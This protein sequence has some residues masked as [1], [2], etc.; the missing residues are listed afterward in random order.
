MEQTS[1]AI[2]FGNDRLIVASL[3]ADQNG[4]ED[5]AVRVRGLVDISI[6]FTQETTPY[7][8]DDNPEY[9]AVI[10]APSGDGTTTFRGMENKDYARF[11]PVISGQG[12][13]VHFGADN[14][15]KYFGITFDQKQTV[16]G[17]ESINRYIFYKCRATNLPSIATETISGSSITPR[18]ILISISVSPVFY[19]KGNGTKGRVIFSVFNSIEDPT[20]FAQFDEGILFPSVSLE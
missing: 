8:A 2:A 6:D 18:D 10:G 16:D 20:M 14:P 1:K 15:V 5:N 17:V 13:G 19:D 11:Y 7:P 3:N 9:F 4:Y 12:K